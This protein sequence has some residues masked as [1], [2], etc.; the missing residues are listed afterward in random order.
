MEVKKATKILH[1][2]LFSIIALLP[3]GKLIT[4]IFGYTFELFSIPV[5]AVVTA[6][7]AVCTVAFSVVQKEQIYDRNFNVIL[8]LLTP[9]SLI[10]AVVLFV[11][12][13]QT[14]IVLRSIVILCCIVC[15]VCCFALDIM[16][17]Q[18]PLRKII[19][20][21]LSGLLSIPVGYVGF[22]TLIF[23]GIGQ[24]TVVQTVQSPAGTYYAEV[25]DSDQ[26]ALGGD[27]IVQV[28]ED[29]GF[30]ALLFKVEKKPQ[31]VYFGQW[32]EFMDM[33]VYWKN[34]NCLVINST[35]YEIQ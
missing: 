20:L 29:K 25:I 10:N 35:E 8:A 30:N 26:G 11:E 17:G 16:N 23:G 28:R 6:L 33:E 5:Y 2:V 27:T 14:D 34:N 19:T 13:I 3:T 24:D 18:K 4:A 31:T 12:C 22:L 1:Y 9:L 21:V 7:L 15:A 32:G